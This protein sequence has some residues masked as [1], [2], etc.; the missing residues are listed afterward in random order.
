MVRQVNISEKKKVYASFLRE[1][2]NWPFH[3]IAIRCNISKSSVECICT[4]GMKCKP[5]KKRSGRLPVL[6]AR[7]KGR[8]LRKF[9]SM[10]EQN[11]NINVG[12]VAMECELHQ[13]S[14]RTLSRIL[15]KSGLNMFGRGE[16]GF[17]L[18]ET[19]KESCL[20]S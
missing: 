9:K 18:P 15:N 4:Q 6:S 7:D 19:K 16:K 5:P 13:V 11:P 10:R 17:S 14:T 3:K 20:C 1:Q 8:I 2:F 12:L